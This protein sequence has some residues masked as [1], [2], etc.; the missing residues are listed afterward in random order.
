L[1]LALGKII[2]SS[3]KGRLR[4]GEPPRPPGADV[5]DCGPDPAMPLFPFSQ[6][7]SFPLFVQIP[8]IDLFLKAERG[9]SKE[10]ELPGN[11]A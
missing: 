10:S 9:D 5:P 4:Q 11:S 2:F 3:T 8:E 6:Q 7:Q 1:T